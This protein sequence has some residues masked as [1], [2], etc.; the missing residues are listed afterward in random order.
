MIYFDN[1]A[2]T[3]PFPE[4]LETYVKVSEQ[5][6]AN[7]SSIHRLGGE[8]ERLINSARRQ[9]AES[10]G[11]KSNEV[12]FTSGGTEANNLAIKGIA[13]EHQKR[14][15]HL[16]TTEIEHAS[17]HATFKQLEKIGFEVTFLPVDAQGRI[18]LT[19]LERSIKDETILVS[20]MHVNNELGTIQ[21]IKEVGEML[22]RHPKIFFHVD[23]IQGIGKV[24][25][26]FD[27]SGIDLC[28][29]SSHKFHGPKGCGFLYVRSGVALSPLL[30]GGEQEFRKRAGTENVPGIIAM[31]KA[32][33]LTL[34]SM[35][36][37][38]NDMIDLKEFIKDQLSRLDPVQIN[39]PERGSAPHILNFSIPGIKPEV[40]IHSLEEKDIFVSTKS[41]C[42]S[43]SDAV[44]RVLEAVGYD[45]DRASSA[46]RVSFNF[47]NTLS[48]GEIFVEA[49]KEVV[50]NLQKVMRE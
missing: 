7:P 26:Q 39:T 12:V 46:I 16:I 34:L 21:P 27:Q 42:S 17:C 25:L 24:P 40:L 31:T 38:M 3:K 23:H 37:R 28:S 41:A 5:Y 8:V 29:F 2:T 6:F 15:R 50:S 22:K 48:E 49:L 36:E 18:S 1:S 44:S 20:I 45:F 47:E 30:T 13:I 35:E 33:R 9:I 4:V 43:K 10:I 32:L 11:V 14:G 19:D